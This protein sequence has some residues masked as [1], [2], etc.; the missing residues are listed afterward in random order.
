MFYR[1]SNIVARI[2]DR[3]LRT[4]APGTSVHHARKFYEN[5]VP[6]YTVYEV[7]CPDH[8]FRK[9][10][11]DGQYLISFSRNHQELIV[12]RPRWLSFSCKDEDCDQHDLPSKAKRFDSFFTQLYCVPLASCN[13]L[14]CKDFFLYMESNQFGLF[15]TSTAQIHDAPAVGG[16]V[17]G[18]P[19][20]EKI[21]FH[22]LRL[23]DGSILDKKV[24]CN[25]FVNLTHN[26][27][28]FLYDDL[29][30]IVSLR[31]QT[32]HILQIRDSGNLVDV[33]A[34]GEFCRED[35]ELFL[36]SNAQYMAL[37]DK[38]QQHQLPGNHTEN[39]IHQDQGQP[40][41]GRS[42]LSGIK[43]RLLS[44]IFQGLWNE[45]RDDTLR[46]QGLRKKFYFHFQ[47]YVDLIIWKVQFMDRHHLLIKFGSVDGGVSR[48]ADHHP[49]FV[50]VYNMDT[51]EIVSFYQNSADELYTLFEQ[52]CD[53]FH[54][55]SRNSMYM[56]FISSHS[57][58]IHAL[59]QLR[60]IKDKA[61]NSSQF[62]KKMLASLPFSCQSQSPSPYFDQ[63]LFR[64]DDKLISATDR[65]R[66]S[67]DHPIK[68]ILRKPPYSLKFK[69]K[70]GPEA[71]SMDGRAKKISSF[72]FHPILPLAL[73]VQ[74]TLFL[75]PSVVNIHFR[76]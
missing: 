18:V 25:D 5:L 1:S 55:T 60:S 57:N 35:D 59:E 51:T 47:D 69:I 10:T 65:H 45:E 26:M 12:Y 48:N 33:R 46:V 61:S 52:F 75:Q 23:E 64:F 70:P 56:N 3:Q 68:F 74:Q 58:N 20:I 38:N 30:A 19:S 4:P 50:A 27:G 49:A 34:I 37:S 24:F 67:T 16:A 22:L 6:S 29:L 66:Q 62:V 17:Q 39:N 36:N 9:F 71:G 13:E 54:A 42:F 53:H 41:L 15:A 73:S 14:I 28:V 8:S 63:S 44:F 76:R 7:E 32:I 43:Q 31:Y 2:F 11:D 72:L 40:N 21:T